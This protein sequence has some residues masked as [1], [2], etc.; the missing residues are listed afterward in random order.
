M[1]SSSFPIKYTYP[2][3]LLTLGQIEII[4]DQCIDNNNLFKEYINISLA[5]LDT[6][7]DNHAK[8][9]LKKFAS[10]F[11]SFAEETFVE[12]MTDKLTGVKCQISGLKSFYALSKHPEALQFVSILFTKCNNVHLNTVV[13]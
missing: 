11:K 1:S 8:Q 9:H 3:N 2:E 10:D 7:K 4:Y 6:I 12:K 13:Q 5:N